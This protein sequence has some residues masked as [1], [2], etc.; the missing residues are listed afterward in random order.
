MVEPGG[1]P[2]YYTRDGK[3][4]G[5]FS[6]VSVRDA[7]QMYFTRIGGGRKF[8]FIECTSQPGTINGVRSRRMNGEICE[9]AG[10]DRRRQGK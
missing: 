1:K 9:L 5:Q 4:D 10:Y 8:S 6:S 3:V 7:A 2:T